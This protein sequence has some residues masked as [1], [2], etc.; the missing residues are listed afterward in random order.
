M[1]S[2]RV[3]SK[4]KN[5]KMLIKVLVIVMVT[6]HTEFIKHTFNRN[7]QLEVIQKDKNL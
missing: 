4:D 5:L 3:L 2:L 7:L 1:D 6:V